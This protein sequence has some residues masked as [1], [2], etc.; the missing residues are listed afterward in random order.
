MGWQ[1][2]IQQFDAT[3]EVE[4]GD[5]LLEAALD[6]DLD[7]PYGC[8][9]G[10]CGAC[11][12]ALVAGRVDLKPYAHFALPD[13][14]RAQGYIL[15]CRAL[16]LG[17]C[18]VALVDPDEPAEF[19]LR[20]VE[21]R[22]AAVDRMT[23]DIVR[24]TLDLDG[25]PFAHAAGQFAALTVPGLPPRDYSMASRPGEPLAFHVRA[26]AN[27]TV[28]RHIVERLRPDDPVDLAG[29]FGVAYLRK[30]HPGPIL[31]LAGGSGL[32][33]I[34]AIVTDALASGCRQP[35]RLMVGMRDERDV[36][37]EEEFAA[38]SAAHPNLAVTYVLSEPA[39]PTARPTGTLAAA[40]EAEPLAAPGTKAYL[41]G[42]PA[43]VESCVAAL[44]AR[45]L[46][47]ADIHADAFYSEADKALMEG[48]P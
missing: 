36:Y 41:A 15:A 11:K 38:L 37:L 1:V 6:A 43:M 20:R 5:T 3:V 26:S 4:P 10:T 18:E 2:R 29:P 31:A 24:V 21:A 25:A 12:T 9:G 47:G 32:A 28:S 45:G 27:G 46:G 35:I 33:P 14:E 40:L 17:P 30:R 48:A 8:Q 44:R 19:P 16:P 42:P 23:H 39:G 13:D 22:V 34:R 7:Y